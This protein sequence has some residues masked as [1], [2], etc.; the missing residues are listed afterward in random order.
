MD[1]IRLQWSIGTGTLAL[2]VAA[3]L[4]STAFAM[5]ALGGGKKGA[6]RNLPDLAV[7]RVTP[8]ASDL[9]QGKTLKV[10][11][12]LR[13]RGTANLKAPHLRIL[14]SADDQPGR[15]DAVFAKTTAAG[16]KARSSRRIHLTVAVP[17]QIAPGAYRLIVCAS[18][19][20]R[21]RNRK[22]DCASSKSRVR[23]GA[24][25]SA[26]PPPSSGQPSPPRGLPPVT[27]PA[28]EPGPGS[29]PVTAKLGACRPNL[30]LGAQ[31]DRSAV[32]E[33]EEIEYTASVRNDPTGA[34]LD[35]EGAETLSGEVAVT[36]SVVDLAM[37][38]E[39]SNGSGRLVLPASA[40]LTTFGAAAPE[41]CPGGEVVGC[42]AGIQ[43]DVGNVF[44]PEGKARSLAAGEEAEIPFR[45]F[46]ELEPED[47]ERIA[48]APAGAVR[49]VVAAETEG[50]DFL[51]TN[52]PVDFSSAPRLED[53]EL[54]VDLP[55]GEDQVSP[56]GSIGPGAEVD[57][58]P[59]AFY[60]V[61][62]ED[63]DTVVTTFQAST[64]N[65]EAITSASVDVS[66][67][68]TIDPSLR[69][70]V[71]PTASP[72][73]ATVGTTAT[74]LVGVA[75]EG[76]V[77]GPPAVVLQGPEDELG[78]LNDE[79]L[80]GDAVAGDGI[81]AGE[82]QVPMDETQKLRVDVLLDGQP[83]SGAV[84]VQALPLGAPTEPAATSNQQ[85]IALGEGRNALADR[86][87]VVMEEGGD[88]SDVAAAAEKVDG[89]VAG[90]I[91]AEMW[92]IAIPPVA[93]EVE[94]DSVLLRSRWPSG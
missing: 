58:E 67:V 43:E 37:W 17:R 70:D 82:V 25:R 21:E 34:C 23:I 20:S 69:P 79:G 24:A 83:R 71:F 19:P 39:V 94:L 41:A 90:R 72:S 49:L 62:E 1:Q 36:T 44:Y 14:L 18:T 27:E 80:D 16:L 7:D 47:L 73:A 26:S 10:T 51:L 74:V 9:T 3:A 45:F 64:S 60:P 93:D 63:P 32:A 61:S 5:G 87:L 59:A 30:T 28:G 33:G 75:L 57:I 22:N 78:T 84:E 68:V 81:W 13:N 35:V 31:A 8:R 86:I 15:G 65:P 66:T 52:A 40:G 42:E 92:Q 76:V 50:G 46:P 6:D 38:L 85:T 4:L 91:D 55:A 12:R 53:V 88:Y 48:D 77:E 11:V 89:S 54:S 29:G 2:A 56:V